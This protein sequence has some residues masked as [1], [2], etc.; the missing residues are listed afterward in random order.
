MRKK[1]RQ[2]FLTKVTQLLIS[3]W[4]PDQSRHRFTLQTK[5][6]IC[7][8]TPTRTGPRDR[9]H[10]TAALTTR[11][12]PGKSLTAIGSVANGIITTSIRGTWKRRLLISRSG[13]AR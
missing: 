7:I 8:S 12:L 1:E 4:E 9:A 2:R 11:R 3:A 5:A 10:S 13:W 6:G